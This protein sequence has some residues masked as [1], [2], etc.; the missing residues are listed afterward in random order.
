MSELYGVVGRNDPSYLLAD[1]VGADPIAIPCEPGNGKIDR[2]TL[3]YKGAD[4]LYVPAG[5]NDVVPTVVDDE[6]VEKSLVVLDED[7]D[8]D[9]VD[10]I[11]EVARAFRAG[12]MIAGRVKLK[13]GAAITPEM[14]LTLRKQ[15]IVF[16]QMVEE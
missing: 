15:N 1:P 8:T 3:M 12:H 7:V 5:T 9:A 13:G 11:H 4:G 6:L 14:L 16:D 2:G 10:D